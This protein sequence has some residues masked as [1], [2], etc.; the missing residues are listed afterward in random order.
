MLPLSSQRRFVVGISTPTWWKVTLS[1]TEVKTLP[2]SIGI[3]TQRQLDG[4][5]EADAMA[6]SGLHL[7]WTGQQDF[8]LPPVSPHETLGLKVC[9][10]WVRTRAQTH[11]SILPPSPG[12]SHQGTALRGEQEPA[13]T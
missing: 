2:S 10:G 8:T 12:H 9:D 3:L 7:L 11:C 5:L 1:L 4:G 13:L 6:L